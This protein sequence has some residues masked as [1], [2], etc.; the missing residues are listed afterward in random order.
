MIGANVTEMV[1]ELQGL[2]YSSEKKEERGH[3]QLR[4]QLQR[5][6]STP[7]CSS[8]LS[9]SEQLPAPAGS[10]SCQLQLPAAG[11]A[12]LAAGQLELQLPSCSWAAAGLQLRPACRSDCNQLL[13]LMKFD[14]QAGGSC[15]PAAAGQLQLQLRDSCAAASPAEPAAGSCSWQ[16]QLPAAAPSW[17]WEQL[18]AAAGYCS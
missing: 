16:L 9:C 18:G 8:R 17:S 14:W 15:S 7:S 3:S 12:G 4:A 1:A 2:A 6:R 10:C 13:Q 5:E 11:S